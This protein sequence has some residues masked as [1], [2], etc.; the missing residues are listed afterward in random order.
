M[1]LCTSFS[2]SSEQML[3][4]IML[5]IISPSRPLLSAFNLH[6]NI[7]T[8]STPEIDLQKQKLKPIIWIQFS[9]IASKK[10]KSLCLVG[11]SILRQFLV[12]RRRRN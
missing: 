6:R 9:E 4:K 8:L 10:R 7:S 3:L 5:K 2:L 11:V 1:N 12:E